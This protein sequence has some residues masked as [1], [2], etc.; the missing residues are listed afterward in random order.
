MT[1][2]PILTAGLI[3]FALP[4]IAAD[5]VPGSH[6]IENW[7]LNEDGKV[8]L[9]EAV[10]RRGDVFY[11]F[12]ANEDDLLQPEEYDM[13]DQA[14]AADMEG[15][16]DHAGGAMK[17]ADGGMTRAFND[18]DGDGLVSRDEFIARTADWIA[19][20]DADGDGTVT[21]ADWA[22]R[23]GQGKGPGKGKGQGNGM[24]QQ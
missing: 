7:D 22:A 13:F 1:R 2:T 14:R 9:D 16:P 11:S 10:E 21:L 19:M 23:R 24:G 18:I 12:D 17:Q 8:T 20:M 5:G 4:V 3:G 6:F 15:Q